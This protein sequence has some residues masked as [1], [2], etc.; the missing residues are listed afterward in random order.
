MKTILLV[1]IVAFS[2]TLASCESCNSKTEGDKVNLIDN[3][4]ISIDNISISSMI[5]IIDS[6]SSESSESIKS[7][8]G[9]GGT[10]KYD[11]EY[12]NSV[13]RQEHYKSIGRNDLAKQE[14]KYR[15]D[16]LRNKTKGK[17]TNK[18]GDDTR[19]Y[20]DSKE[21]EEDLKAIDEYMKNN[22]EF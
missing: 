2:F 18:D 19:I 8:K 14:A 13:N 3:D 11:S 21:Q 6:M 9:S 17:Y 7:S 5:G 1:I 12:W 20:K 22:P 10:E 15:Q 16:R 4:S